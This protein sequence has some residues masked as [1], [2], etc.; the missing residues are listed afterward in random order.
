M[1]LK[2]DSRGG[3]CI[4]KSQELGQEGSTVR[5]IH[6]K[7]EKAQRRQR[8]HNEGV[9]KKVGS[10]CVLLPSDVFLSSSC[11]LVFLLFV[12]RPR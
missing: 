2:V 11:F 6:H 12:W 5:I 9:S 10:L 4:K 3:V 1:T 8:E 7:A